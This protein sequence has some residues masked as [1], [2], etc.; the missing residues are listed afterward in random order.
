MGPWYW[1]LVGHFA[2]QVQ[3]EQA[4][5][6]G[7]LQVAQVAVTDWFQVEQVVVIGSLQAAQEYFPWP[8]GPQ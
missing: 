8:L 4:V 2:E 6:I 3:V 1:M 5:V 7:S